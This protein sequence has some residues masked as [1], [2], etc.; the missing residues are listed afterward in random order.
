[1]PSDVKKK[2]GRNWSRYKAF[3]VFRSP[4]DTVI[5]DFFWLQSGKD[6]ATRIEFS[7]SAFEEFLDVRSDR[8]AR[9]ERLY[10][11]VA[12]HP[13]ILILKYEEFPRNLEELSE[14][15]DLGLEWVQRFGTLRAKGETRQ[16]GVKPR[17][18]FDANPHLR[19]AVQKLFPRMVSELGYED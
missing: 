1:M 7:N 6:R 14:E 10:V 15:L 18:V 4:F 11:D 19:A 12:N 3:I 9:N 5:S 8:L 13:E 17:A 2:L 16:P